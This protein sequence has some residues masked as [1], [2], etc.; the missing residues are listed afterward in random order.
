MSWI[1]SIAKT[2]SHQT[3]NRNLSTAPTTCLIY[4]I[5]LSNNKI[6]NLNQEYQ[7]FLLV[8]FYYVNEIP[9]NK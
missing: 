3:L 2:P 6:S 9:N 7:I 5:Y 4:L 1:L 8:H